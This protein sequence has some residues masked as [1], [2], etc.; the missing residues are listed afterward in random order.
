MSKTVSLAVMLVT[1]S[2]ALGARAGAPGEPS[3]FVAETDGS[4][5]QLLVA[6]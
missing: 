5:S 6:S 4:A 2:A 1:F 3:T